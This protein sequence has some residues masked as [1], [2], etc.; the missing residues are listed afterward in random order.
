MPQDI[1]KIYA[2]IDESGNSD[3]NTAKSGAS[4]LFICTAV[5]IKENNLSEI[6]ECIKKLQASGGQELKSSKIG[7]DHGRRIKILQAIRRTI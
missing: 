2:F 3:L 1:S 7:G 5:I 6:E 4:N